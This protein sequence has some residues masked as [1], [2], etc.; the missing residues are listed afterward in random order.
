MSFQPLVFSG[1]VIGQSSGGG[2]GSGTVTSVG[3]SLPGSIFTISGS[4]VT[5]SGTLTGSLISQTA[6]TFLASPDGSSGLPTFRAIV[7]SDIPSLSG[8]YANTALSNLTS[9]AINQS[10][11]TPTNLTLSLGSSGNS[12]GQIWAGG[13]YNN[14]SGLFLD[15]TNY[16]MYDFDGVE[17]LDLGVHNAPLN[18]HPA[19]NGARQVRFIDDGGTNYV[20]IKAPSSITSSYVLNLP[21]A[22]GS[23][24]TFLQNDGSGNLSWATSS[25]GANTTL[26]NLTSSTAINQNLLPNGNASFSLGSLSLPWNT[27][28]AD[29]WAA[30]N[31][32]NVLAQISTSGSTPSGTNT[33]GTL[34][35]PTASGPAGIYTPNIAGGSESIYI[36]TGNASSGNSGNL[37]FYTGTASGTRGQLQFQNGSQG[38][39][40]Y[41]WTSTDTNGSGSWVAPSTPTFSDSIVN[42]S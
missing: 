28:Y 34:T 32:S 5:T 11:L 36:E 3:L 40:G 27:S 39:A 2:G 1:F 31:G 20:T 14:T 16:A 23:A 33:F 24:S 21:I 18:I 17:A 6:N 4:P 22:Q 30:S 7:A 26:S 41:V 12:W 29:T 38:T 25:S 37:I 15:V 42:T 19:G 35:F 8:L 9:T 10:L 13:I